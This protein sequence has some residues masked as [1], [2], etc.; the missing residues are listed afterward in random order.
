M[1]V[2]EVVRISDFKYLWEIKP[3]GFADSLDVGFQ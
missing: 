2:A 3:I 1:L